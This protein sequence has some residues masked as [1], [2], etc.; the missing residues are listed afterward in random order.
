MSLKLSFIIPCYNVEKFIQHCLDSI[1]AVQLREDEYEVLCFND[2][3]K[4]STPQI[5]DRYA[6]FHAN[7]HVFHSSQNVGM[8]KGRNNLINHSKGEYVWFVDSDDSICSENVPTLLNIAESGNLDVL[9][10]NYNEINEAGI[11]VKTCKFFGETRITS[12]IDFVKSVFKN[13]LTNHIGFVWRFLYRREYLLTNNIL[14]P[15]GNWEDTLY[16]P[17]AMIL[18]N[19]IQST[20][21][22]GYEY[23]HHQSSICR[24]MEKKYPGQW[25]YEYSFVAGYDLLQFANTIDDEYLK[26]QICSIS[27]EYFNWF[28][29]YLCRSGYRERNV[30]YRSIR[31]NYEERVIPL[32]Q[33]LNFVPRLFLLPYIGRFFAECAALV[34]VIKHYC[35]KK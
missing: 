32:W 3:S 25:V 14:F 9:A 23:R 4:D 33:Y 8:S 1:L 30:F 35:I 17:K 5:L 12:G 29:P 6:E 20:F 24:T 31:E 15:E 2:G 21:I 22:V 7:I 10:F 19:K 11:V 18:A 27:A 34:Y 26:M 28:P 16:M 13:Q